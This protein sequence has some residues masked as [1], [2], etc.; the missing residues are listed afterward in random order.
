MVTPVGDWIVVTSVA[1]AGICL[2]SRLGTA[3][4]VVEIKPS[5]P[6]ASVVNL[7]FPENILGK[8]KAYRSYG[9]VEW[10][11]ERVHVKYKALMYSNAEMFEMTA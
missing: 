11:W 4:T 5:K 8:D 3:C 2:G 9:I 1:L 6:T 10:G 7:G